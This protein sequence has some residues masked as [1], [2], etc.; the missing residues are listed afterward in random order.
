[1]KLQS[2]SIARHI[3]FKILRFN[4]LTKLAMNSRK[5]TNFSLQRKLIGVP[6]YS[7]FL[8]M[9]LTK[10]RNSTRRTESI[11]TRDNLHWPLFLWKVKRVNCSGTLFRDFVS[12]PSFIVRWGCSGA[13]L[14]A[15][16]MFYHSSAFKL[17]PVTPSHWRWKR[18]C[19]KG[20][21]LGTCYNCVVSLSLL[22]RDHLICGPFLFF[23]FSKSVIS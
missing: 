20:P 13:F 17:D 4:V 22:V 18:V 7:R 21:I 8:L 2:T 1:M 14:W 9:A 12:W 3:H 15:F 23:Y 5:L 6:N 19:F 11:L 10:D 16:V